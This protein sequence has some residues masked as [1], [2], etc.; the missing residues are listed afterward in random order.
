MQL[1]IRA[2]ITAAFAVVM[3]VL[4]IAVATTAYVAMGGALQDEIDSG[5]RF[6]AESALHIPTPADLGRPDPRLQEPTEAFDQVLTRAGRVLRATSGFH[7]PLL[8]PAELATVHGPIFSS[9]DVPDV[10]DGARLLAIPMGRNILVVGV[11]MS[12]R[13][14]ALHELVLVLAAGGAV[15]VLVACLAG[16]IVAGWALRPVERIRAQASAIT[17]SGLDRRLPVPR[18]R[19]ELFRLANT[20]NE[21]LDRLTLA[22]Q[23]ERDFLERAGHELRTPLSALRAEVDLALHRRR[24]AEELTAALRSVGQETDRLARLA[25]DLLVLARADGGRLP[26]HR[27]PVRLRELLESAAALFS[28]RAAELGVTLTVD[29]PDT[30]HRLDPMRIRQAL[31]NLVDNALRHTPR[32]GTVTLRADDEASGCRI[33]VRDTG[34]GFDPAAAGDDTG[35]G[36]RIVDAIARG[37]GGE[38]QVGREPSGGAVV[39]LVLTRG[40]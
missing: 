29:A 4:L 18:T 11:S 3:T 32:G 21:M 14:D 31:V 10:A 25:D 5:L 37:H 22:V 35:L 40:A 38:L 27:E 9:R 7:T 26:L 33:E 1:P 30:E 13:T 6:R 19:D 39:A 8:T 24:T 17:V 20:L 34:P 23:H 2:R 36:L 12:D 15:A 28:A 16:W